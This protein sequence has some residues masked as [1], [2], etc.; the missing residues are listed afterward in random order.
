MT[1]TVSLNG[2]GEARAYST[3]NGDL[4]Y[5]LAPE[6]LHGSTDET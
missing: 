1:D 3:E 4:F 2:A 6:L 5:L